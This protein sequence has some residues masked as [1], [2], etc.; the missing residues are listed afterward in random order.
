LARPWSRAKSVSIRGDLRRALQVAHV[1]QDRWGHLASLLRVVQALVDNYEDNIPRTE[2]RT[3]H[4]RKLIHQN[5]AAD[6][7]LP[8]EGVALDGPYDAIPFADLLDLDFLRFFH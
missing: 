2:V 4:D 6:P 5:P 1:L 3:D 7:A 8:S